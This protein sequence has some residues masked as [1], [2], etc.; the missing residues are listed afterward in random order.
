MAY[1]PPFVDAAGLH[2]NGYEDILQDNLTGFL[3]IYGATQYVAPDS[4]IYQFISILSLKQADAN[5]ALQLAYNQS[6]PLTAVG[7]GLD[8]LG[9]IIGIARQ[10]ATSSTAILNLTGVSGRVLNNAFA[11]D[12]NGNLWS[13]PNGTTFIL[14]AASVTATCST[15][16]NVSADANTIT[17]IATPILGWTSVTN[18]SDAIVGTNVET[19]SA[20]RARMAISVARPSLTMLDSL[21]ADVLAVPGV[22]R[23]NPGQPTSGSQGSSIENPT[24]STDSWGNPAHSV[25][26][27]VEGGTDA[28]VAQAIYGAVGIGPFTNGTTNVTVTDPVTGFSIS[29]GFYRPTYIQVAVNVVLTA[30]NAGVVTTAQ[31]LAVQAALVAYI[32]ANPIG[33]VL[34]YSALIAIAQ[35]SGTNYYVSTLQ[36]GTV[37]ATTTASITTG[38]PTMTV[39]SAA[40]IS[41]GMVVFDVTNPSN[42]TQGVT[43]SSISGTTITLSANAAGTAP[44]DTVSFA[45]M[46]SSGQTPGAFYDTYQ[47]SNGLVF[48]S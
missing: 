24:G 35:A 47:T 41:P 8:R 19:D 28:A 33:A 32:N 9:K 43:V 16:G 4:F 23:I 18:P 13:I 7:A 46:A 3:N 21:K 34:N 22:T 12:S 2:V 40:G 44:S 29:I 36:T 1:T 48:V 38:S 30:I 27:V 10:P 6:S 42:L 39:V 31:E 20:Y 26:M 37:A 5:A 11:I 14:G 45:T 17:G 25:S 15:P